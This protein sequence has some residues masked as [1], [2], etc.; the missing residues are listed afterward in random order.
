MLFLHSQILSCLLNLGWITSV[1]KLLN[2]REL[3]WQLTALV[4]L[5][6]KRESPHYEVDEAKARRV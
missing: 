1:W 2:G 6:M 5:G 3:P 4:I